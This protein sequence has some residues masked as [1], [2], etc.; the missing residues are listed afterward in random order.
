VAQGG[1][2]RG[3]VAVAVVRQDADDVETGEGNGDELEDTA[4]DTVAAPPPPPSLSRCLATT[5][6]RFHLSTPST[7]PRSGVLLRLCA[8]DLIASGS[9]VRDDDVDERGGDELLDNGE[10]ERREDAHEDGDDKDV[11]EHEEPPVTP[12]FL[13]GRFFRS[14][15]AVV[16]VCL[17]RRRGLSG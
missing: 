2:W 7:S 3:V 6:S 14:A 8:D 1:A 11:D 4:V 17:S 12:A 9:L 13:D 10:I 15:A 5:T 16:A